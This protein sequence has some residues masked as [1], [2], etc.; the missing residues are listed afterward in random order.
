M[1]QI[2]LNTSAKIRIAEEGGGKTYWM[3]LV[4]FCS[5]LHCIFLPG[6]LH[7]PVHPG[8][9]PFEYISFYVAVG[10][11]SLPHLCLVPLS[12]KKRRHRWL[13]GAMS[14]DAGGRNAPL[15]ILEYVNYGYTNFIQER[16]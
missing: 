8:E 9:A 4:P 15:F 14:T 12:F 5:P 7:F 13:L 2:D 11:S 3:S 10:T 1:A 16:W 6:Q